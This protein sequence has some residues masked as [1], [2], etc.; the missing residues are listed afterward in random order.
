VGQIKTWA[1]ANGGAPAVIIVG[2]GLLA[3]SLVLGIALMVAG[4]LWFFVRLEPIRK[5]LITW[6]G[7]DPLQPDIPVAGLSIGHAGEVHVHQ[8]DGGARRAEE[9]RREIRLA[10]L[11]S[12]RTFVI[13]GKTYEDV[14][15]IGP[16]V[17]AI[18]NGTVMEEPHFPSDLDAIFWRV[19]D[20][21]KEVAG[22]IAFDNCVLRRCRFFAIGVAI[23]E[24]KWPE[25]LANT[26]VHDGPMPAL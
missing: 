12:E 3:V 19:P 15:F 13:K 10:D 2:V 11:V 9:P 5:R 18:T 1:V 21:K 22:A 8:G 16:A 24:S 26:T 7:G 23:P 6:L 20:D 4:S 25:I 14:D 17:I